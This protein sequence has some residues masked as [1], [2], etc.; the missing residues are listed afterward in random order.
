MQPETQNPAKGR[1]FAGAQSQAGGS[2]T[3]STAGAPLALI[4]ARLENVRRCGRGH[5]ADCPRGHS[6]RGTLAIH[7]GASGAVLMCCHAGCT[8]GEVL[9]AVGLSVTDLFPVRLPPASPEA[10]REAMRA[11]REAGWAAALPAL[12]LEA[13]VVEAAARRM[14]RDDRLTWS[15]LQRLARAAERIADARARLAPAPRWKPEARR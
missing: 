6:S 5:R 3:H 4:L 8:P 13:A 11:A 2:R 14:L 15:D 12:E 1:G 10:R 7:E 9:G